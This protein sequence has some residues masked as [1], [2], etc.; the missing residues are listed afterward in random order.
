MKILSIVSLCALGALSAHAQ[1]II[2]H[3]CTDLSAIPESAI[4]EARAQLH[5][6]YGH[7]SHGSQLTTGMTGLIG[8]TN[9]VGYKGDIYRWNN[10]GDEGALDLHDYAMPGDLGHNGDLTWAANTRTYLDNLDNS[11]VNVI[12]WSWCGGVSDNTAAGIDTYLNAM[13]QLEIDYPDVA[14]V[15]MTGHLDI[16]NNTTLKANNQ[17]IRDYCVA[18][19][20][21][22]YDFADIESYD[23]DGTYYRYAHDD[24]SYYDSRIRYQGNW[25][26]AWQDA[27]TEGVDWFDCDAAHSQPLNGNL[28]AYAAWWLWARLAGWEGTG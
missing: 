8:Q 21:I 26:M 9:L 5:I 22:L 18:N 16:W 17:R 19:D 15:Y 13:N 25:A 23:P 11:D 20:K 7:T 28:K 10:G 2:D 24:C 27:N 14:F 1:I 12:I 3:T 4:N 6:A